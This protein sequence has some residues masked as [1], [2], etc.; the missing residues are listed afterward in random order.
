VV[1]RYARDIS[2]NLENTATVIVPVP[3]D[4]TPFKI[5]SINEK[6]FFEGEG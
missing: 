3:N 4:A 5:A 1:N 2:G 6:F